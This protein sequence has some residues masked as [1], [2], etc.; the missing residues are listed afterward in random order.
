MKVLV[1][2]CAGFIGSH[3]CEKLLSNNFNVVGIDN[4]DTFYSKE[5]KQNNLSHFIN[6]PNFVFENIDLTDKKKL[7][8]LSKADIVIHLA[9]KAG[10]RPSIAAPLNY[11]KHNIE[12]TQN[13]LDF[14]VEKGI[15][16]YIFAS[17]SSIYGNTK[18][19]PFV[20]QDA[21]NQPISPYAYSKKT[22]EMMSYTYHDIYN[23][24]VLNLRFFTVYGPR[25][26][27]DLAIH[28]FVK[29]IKNNKPIEMYGDGTSARDYTYVEDTVQGVFNAVK[30]ILD[31]DKVFE[32]INLGNHYPVTLKELINT[33]YKVL[34]T[35]PNI[36]EKEHQKGEVDVTY[37]DI[38]KA[39][40]ILNYQPKTNFEDG[41]KHFI[42]WFNQ[43]YG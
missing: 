13:V 24:D 23:I 22:G 21:C 8:S 15:N 35:T 17:S 6:H 20:E 39:Q 19:T 4:F 14:L 38:K 34:K 40:T 2:G 18:Q 31:N 10:V 41:I 7:F 42:N 9:A 28:K 27:P 43:Y 5:Q 26:R 1:T 3:L 25:Q 36:I 37:A 32:H 12:A 16:K 29:L 11:V 33:I 30:Y